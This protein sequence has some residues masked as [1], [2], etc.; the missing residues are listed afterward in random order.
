MVDGRARAMPYFAELQSIHPDSRTSTQRWSVNRRKLVRVLGQRSTGYGALTNLVDKSLVVV[1]ERDDHESRFQ[2]LE[3]VRE[4]A[5]LKLTSRAPEASSA[6]YQQHAMYF[7]EFVRGV[8]SHT[9]W[10]ARV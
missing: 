2:F 7:G 9:A 4:Y 5:Q 3:R 10:G 1:A 8:K 6:P